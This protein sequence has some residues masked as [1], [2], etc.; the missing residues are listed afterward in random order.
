MCGI[1]GIVDFS[2]RKIDRS[3]IKAMCEAFKHRGPDDEGIYESSV[4]KGSN[5]RLSLAL[6]H[7]RLSIIDLETGHQPI[8]NENKTICIVHNGMIYNFKQLRRDLE[9]NSHKFKTNSDAE[10]IVHLYEEKGEELVKYLKG[11]FSFAI[12]DSSR[13]KLLLAKDFLGKKPLFYSH[14][15]NKVIFASG[16]SAL[17]KEGTISKDIDLACIDSYLTYLCIPAPNSIYRSI[18]K[19]QPAHMLIF[20]KGKKREICYWRLDFRKKID[21]NQHDAIQ[22]LLRIL[23]EAVR[24][25]L[26]SDVPLGVLL[27]GGVDSSTLVALIRQVSGEK[28]RTFSIGFKESNFDELPYARIVAER[29]STEHHEF[30]VEPKI[31]DLLPK[32]VRHF[33]EPY[34]DSSAIPTYYLAQMASKYVKVAFNGD[35]GDEVFIGYKHHLANL[36]AERVNKL[37]Y[38]LRNGILLNTVKFFTKGAPYNSTIGHLRR[39]AEAFNLPRGQRYKSWVCFYNEGMKDNLYSEDFKREMKENVADDIISA[40]FKENTDLDVIE[41]SLLADI[42]VNLPNDLIVKMDIACMANF[43]EARSP[44][45][46][47]QLVEFVAS[48]PMEI[49]MK[50]F[51]LKYLLKSAVNNIVPHQNLYRPKKGFAVPLGH[52][53]R[54]DLKT[55]LFD[56]LLNNSARIGKIFN[57]KYVRELIKQHVEGRR[58]YSHH[59]WLLLML[60]LWFLEFE[61]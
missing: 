33:G 5:S 58:D 26:I 7:R 23:K 56:T 21:I 35:G 19:V 32:L 17:F 55:F 36:L 25:R 59:L 28:I 9:K 10:V 12:W 52:W 45:L 30:T 51:R 48:L 31:Q 29:F 43:L 16:L 44:F 14:F 1:A 40:I 38:I 2:G 24:V 13:R 57:M 8:F 49:K 50:N 11:T 54:K 34:A 37:P 20:E 42:S 39:F 41:A 61:E 22:E 4:N 53:F 47:R 60:E 46:D 15:D 27:S 18:K 3:K 6:G